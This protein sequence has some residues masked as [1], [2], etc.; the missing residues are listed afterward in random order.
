MVYLVV[1]EFISKYYDTEAFILF[2]ISS[3]I[4]IF[5]DAK[6]YEK[7]NMMR[8]YKFSKY[9]GYFYI[10]F[11]IMLLIVKKYLL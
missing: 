11:G 3:L 4:L 10:V 6:G 8:E 2:I 9:A 5:V 1:L 7:V